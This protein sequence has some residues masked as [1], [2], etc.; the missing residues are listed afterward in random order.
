MSSYTPAS[1]SRARRIV[2][3]LA[4]IGMITGLSGCV[5]VPA[6]G[7]YHHGYYDRDYY[8]HWR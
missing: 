2:L 3:A 6:G 4:A 8:H 5:V 7:Y 1:R